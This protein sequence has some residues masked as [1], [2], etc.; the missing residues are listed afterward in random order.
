MERTNYHEIWTIDKF[1]RSVTDG[2]YQSYE[3]EI[4]FPKTS[5]SKMP[6]CQELPIYD[7]PLWAKLLDPPE[8]SPLHPIVNKS[9]NIERC[10]NKMHKIV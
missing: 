10:G 6:K 8:F 7:I 4:F 1:R 3:I 2:R 5:F 9:C